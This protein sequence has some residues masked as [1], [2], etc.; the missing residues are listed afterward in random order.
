[1]PIC[2]ASQLRHPGIRPGIRK[3]R[4]GLPSQQT[5]S[6]QIYRNLRVAVGLKDEHLRTDLPLSLPTLGPLSPRSSPANQSTTCSPRLPID[7]SAMKNVDYPKSTALVTGATS[8]IGLS[9]AIELLSRGIGRL[10]VVGKQQQ[11]L[12]RTRR[13]FAR[14]VAT[15][16]KFDASSLT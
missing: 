7:L 4:R 9:I 15:V 12:D 16:K 10:V 11:K 5:D 6:C 13:N 1:M 14:S 8:G 3:F 2:A